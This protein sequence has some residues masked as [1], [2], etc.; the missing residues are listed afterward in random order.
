MNYMLVI[1]LILQ[2]GGDEYNLII[3]SLYLLLFLILIF[4]GQRIQFHIALI[5]VGGL[6]KQ[7]NVMRTMARKDTLH[8]IKKYSERKDLE[9]EVDRL[10]NSFMIQPESLDPAGIVRKL[11]HILNLRENKFLN[12]IKK[13]ITK[14]T[15]EYKIR[16]IGNML[17]ATLALN[18]LYKV[19]EHYYLLAKKTGNFYLVAQLQML[20]PLLFNEAKAYLHAVTAFKFGTPIGDSIGPLVAYNLIHDKASYLIDIKKDY[21]KD[22]DVYTIKRNNRILHVV[23]AQGPGGNVGKP[24]EAIKRLIENR[25]NDGSGI[26]LVIM[27]DAALKLEGE[28]SGSVAEGVGA[29]IGGIGVEKFKIE[30]EV[31]KYNIPIIALVIKESFLEAITTIKKDIADSIK[32]II[33]RID[34]IILSESKENDEIIIAGVGN[35]IGVL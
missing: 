16:N 5:E 26:K 15:L 32:N 8:E 14:K 12:D 34:H 27:I 24:G 13:L 19:L 22:T 25:K 35:S 21:V 3:Q 17:E 6:I 20:V 7:L 11:E 9:L 2:I 30:E 18:T 31:T 10:I 4:F 33:S 29:A 23:K 1:N 28:K